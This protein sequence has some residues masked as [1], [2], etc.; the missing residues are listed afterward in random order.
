[1]GRTVWS[2]CHIYLGNIYIV[3]SRQHLIGTFMAHQQ[4]KKV[5]FRVL[6]CLY[7]LCAPIICVLCAFI[8]ASLSMHNFFVQSR[9]SFLS[10]HFIPKVS[11]DHPFKLFGDHLLRLEKTTPILSYGRKDSQRR[12]FNPNWFKGNTR[13]SWKEPP[14][15]L[16]LGEN[17]LKGPRCSPNPL[18]VITPYKIE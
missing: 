18:K 2:R 11:K 14:P 10:F 8:W 6:A 12:E 16:P 7:D 17:S 15:T 1:M 13:W 3:S 4:A 9:F 5:L